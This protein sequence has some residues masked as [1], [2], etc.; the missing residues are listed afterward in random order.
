M[1][2]EI[3]LETF[4]ANLPLF[5][6]LG[7]DALARLAAG[8]KRLRLARGEAL[9]REGEPPEGF[10]AVVYGEIRLSRGA[11]RLVDLIGPG[12]TFGEPVMFLAKPYLVGASAA[13]DSLVVRVSKDAVDA[14][15]DRNPRF[16]HRVI[17]SLARRSEVLM[18]EI[19]SYALGSAAERLIA[20]LLRREPLDASGARDLTL[21]M[22]KRALASRLNLSTEHLSRIFGELSDKGLIEVRGRRL[23]VPDLARLRAYRAA[24]SRARYSGTGEARPLN[25]TRRACASR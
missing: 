16:A 6:G 12:K 2:R 17:A 21:P 3:K 7:A 23:H 18:R 20:Y 8:A 10:Y 25:S 1:R 13:K 4:L 14:E 22:A 15:I 24:R 9:F 5:R 11:G 19:D